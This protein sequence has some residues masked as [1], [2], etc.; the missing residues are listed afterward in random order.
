[1]EIYAAKMGIDVTPMSRFTNVRLR[2]HI[3]SYLVFS[4]LVGV[5]L[6]ISYVKRLANH[7]KHNLCYHSQVWGW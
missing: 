3:S 5:L 7:N 1:M 4:K 6:V 2:L